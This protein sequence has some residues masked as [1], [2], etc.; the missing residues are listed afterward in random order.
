MNIQAALQQIRDN[1][2]ASHLAI[3]AG[4]YLTITFG[5]ATIAYWRRHPY[6]HAI[7]GISI[8]APFLCMGLA[9]VV[10]FF[11]AF[12]AF[13]VEFS[14]GRNIYS[15]KN[16]KSLLAF[17][18]SE[19]SLTQYLMNSYLTVAGTNQEWRNYMTHLASDEPLVWAN[20]RVKEMKQEA[21][22]LKI[23]TL[24]ASQIEAI[25]Q[26]AGQ[27]DYQ[28]ATQDKAPAHAK[29]RSKPFRTFVL[30]PGI[31]CISSLVTVFFSVIYSKPYT[32]D[33]GIPWLALVAYLALFVGFFSGLF[34]LWGFLMTLK[35]KWHQKRFA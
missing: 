21:R 16:G 4:L 28:L 25:F 3:I 19:S 15:V 33:Q 12:S 20:L 26:H 17:I 22:R 18:Q 11:W 30:I 10:C 5:P 27:V 32:T 13:P 24:S 35:G 34:T 8:I 9:N 14:F 7:L 29:L 23:K 1:N 2:S 31:I 6:R